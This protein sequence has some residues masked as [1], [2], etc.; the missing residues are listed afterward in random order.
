M[1]TKT[2]NIV[3]ETLKELADWSEN[4]EAQNSPFTLFMDLTGFSEAQ[5]GEH[6]S[7]AWS[8]FMGYKEYVMLGD[9]LKLFENYGYE[10][11]YKAIEEIIKE[12]N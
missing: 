11:I 2:E 7:E 5:Y 10:T 4:F 6:L 8:Y 3:K 1:N 9:A 12:L